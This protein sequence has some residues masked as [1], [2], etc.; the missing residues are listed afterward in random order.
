MFYRSL[1]EFKKD[2][3]YDIEDIW[4]PRVTSIVSIKNKPAL[5]RYYG[6][7][8][9]FA[10]ATA[11]MNRSA[12]EGTLVHEVAEAIFRGESPTI[13][14]SVRPVIEE[15]MS[16][17]EQARIVPQQIETQVIS[18]KHGYAGTLDVLAE[19]DGKLGVLDIKTSQAIY[20][21]Y[22]IQTAAYAEALREDKSIPELTRWILRLDQVQLC[23]N[24]CGARLRTKGGNVKVKNGKGRDYYKSRDCAHVWG[25]VAGEIELRELDNLEH[26]TKAFLAAKQLWEWEHQEWLSQLI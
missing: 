10:H 21:D 20:R 11:A 17:N 14:D 24:G 16:F 23:L 3:G 5:Y 19:V 2:N 12:E 8:K 13:P 1:K 22:G 9:S 26:D 4:Y 7:H 6:E 18:K 25:P 15:F